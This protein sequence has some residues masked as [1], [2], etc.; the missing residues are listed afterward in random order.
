MKV[1]IVSIT[2]TALFISCGTP[3]KRH[4]FPNFRYLESNYDNAWNSVIDYFAN[5]NIPVKT[6]EKESGL[7]YAETIGFSEEWIDCGSPSV[8]G[9]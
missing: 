5:N 9:G 4:D 6:L 3:A 1:F 7:I 8:N 2:L